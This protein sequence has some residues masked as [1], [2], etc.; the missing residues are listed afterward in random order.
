MTARCAIASPQ[1][2]PA[3]AAIARIVQP[4]ER[5]EDLFQRLFGHARAEIADRKP[6]STRGRYGQRNLDSAA[7]GGIADGVAQ[8]VLHRAA[9]HFAVA[10]QRDGGTS[11]GFHAMPQG[12]CAAST[13]QSSTSVVTN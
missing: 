6:S 12:R 3:G 4:E 1:A 7:G 8:H 10:A 5:G 13:R 2:D 9:Q 11:A